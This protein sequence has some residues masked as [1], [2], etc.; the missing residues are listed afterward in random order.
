MVKI[1][2]SPQEVESMFRQIKH[3]KFHTGKPQNWM[4]GDDGSVRAQSVMW[5]FCWACNGD[6]SIEA[7]I[8]SRDIFNE[9][10]PFNFSFFLARVGYYF[11]KSHRYADGS[12]E[13]ELEELL[14][15]TCPN[16]RSNNIL[17]I[18]YGEILMDEDQV[19]PQ[20]SNKANQIFSPARCHW[21]CKDCGNEFS[22]EI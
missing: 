14:G 21:L 20:K 13:R 1:K 10:F 5:L 8:D 7:M 2:V 15:K 22:R 4:V 11:S 18:D 19:M 9:I 6:G 16:C 17:N 12:W 3:A